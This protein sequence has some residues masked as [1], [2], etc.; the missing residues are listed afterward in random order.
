MGKRITKKIIPGT[1][2]DGAVQQKIG[3]KKN[4]IIFK[5][6]KNWEINFFRFNLSCSSS[7]G[8]S[9]KD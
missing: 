2:I 8:K 5:K 1:P 7:N 9:K 3:V 6:T 4:K